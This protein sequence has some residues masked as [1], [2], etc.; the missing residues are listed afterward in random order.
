MQWHLRG[1]VARCVHLGLRINR[2][3]QADDK[4]IFVWKFI[5]FNCKASWDGLPTALSLGH[6]SYPDSLSYFFPKGVFS[7]R[8]FWPLYN[9]SNV[10]V[11]S[12]PSPLIPT[13][14]SLH[15]SNVYLFLNVQG[16]DF[17]SG[18]YIVYQLRIYACMYTSGNIWGWFSV[19][20][21]K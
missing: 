6:G 20:F 15:V 1:S 17:I 13:W 7:G 4:V 21:P 2:P 14:W 19:G 8:F 12:C 18:L 3:P 16:I 5:L 9:R 10:L 11:S